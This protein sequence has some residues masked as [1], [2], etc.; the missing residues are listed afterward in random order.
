M[1]EVIFAIPG[2]LA[3]PTGGYAYDRQILAHLPAHGVTV[4]H[5]AL[6]GSFPLASVPDLGETGYLL[7][8]TPPDAVVMVD[9]LA[10]GAMTELV[11]KDID[12]TFV[13]L[14]HHPLA[15]ETG[16]T[17]RLRRAL[18]YT[19]RTALARAAHVIVTSPITAATLVADYSVPPEKITVAIPGTEPASRAK[20]SGRGAPHML[21]VGTI[22]PRKAYTVLA[23][24]LGGLK[25]FA[26][27]LDIAGET[28]RVEG[29]YDRV[30]EALSRFGIADR[31]RF[32]GVLDKPALDAAYAGADLFLMPS[33]YEGYGM[34]L[35]EAMARGLPIVCTTGGAAAQTVPDG[36]G[37]KVPPGDAV[38]LRD[39]IARLIQDPALRSRIADA[40]WQ[41]GQS[42]PTW[43]DAAG[44]IAGAIQRVSAGRAIS[45]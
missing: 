31:V 36:A 1:P 3:T 26:W 27:T 10:F 25:D 17:D 22:S 38:A 11:L 14:V 7:K 43:A 16:L 24:A 4:S 45:P 35:A 44:V 23:E 15:L 30:L 18:A 41:A 5:L 34:V 28:D 39:A 40:S 37:L 33:L 9:G 2:D 8:H 29:E 6:P 42:L 20:G 21:C 32:I 13:A 19:E 12:R